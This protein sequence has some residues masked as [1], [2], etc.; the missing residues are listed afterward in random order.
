MM[1]FKCR[2]SVVEFIKIMHESRVILCVQK[3]IASVNSFVDYM[4]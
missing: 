3:Y 2:S 4:V 1:K